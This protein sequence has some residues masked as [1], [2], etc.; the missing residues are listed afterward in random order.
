MGLHIID[1]PY[2]IVDISAALKG[3]WDN[4]PCHGLVIYA[5]QFSTPVANITREDDASMLG[6]KSFSI[7]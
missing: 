1:R 3:D 2:T 7:P 6:S 5:S 4:K